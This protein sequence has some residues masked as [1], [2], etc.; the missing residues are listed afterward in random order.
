MALD[1]F[2][3]WACTC[4]SRGGSVQIYVDLCHLPT[5]RSWTPTSTFKCQLLKSVLARNWTIIYEVLAMFQALW[6]AQRLSVS[7][8]SMPSALVELT[9]MPHK[10]STCRGHAVLLGLREQDSPLVWLGSCQKS[11]SQV[12]QHFFPPESRAHSQWFV[13]EAPPHTRCAPVQADATFQ[14]HSPIC[15]FSSCQLRNKPSC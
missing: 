14:H 12:D 15:P 1:F 10:L 13:R 5:K 7:K 2:C 4:F 11:E 6:Q 9:L 8:T 3:T